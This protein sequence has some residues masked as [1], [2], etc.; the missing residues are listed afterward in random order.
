MGSGI[1]DRCLG[2]YDC[3]QVSQISWVVDRYH[4]WI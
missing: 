2:G 4:M 1:V 3:R